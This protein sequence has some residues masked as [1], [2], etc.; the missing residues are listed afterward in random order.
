MDFKKLIIFCIFYIFFVNKIQSFEYR[1]Y[2]YS[3]D[4][5]KDKL[6]HIY[7]TSMCSEYGLIQYNSG[8]SKVTIVKSINYGTCEID[9]NSTL[10][11]TTYFVNKCTKLN[12]ISSVFIRV[13]PDQNPYK[14]TDFCNSISFINNNCDN[15]IVKSFKNNTCFNSNDYDFNNNNNNNNSS[16]NNNNNNNS[17]E[18]NNFKRISCR[19]SYIDIDVCN[20]GCSDIQC[21]FNATI[22]SN[23]AS[24]PE[25][26]FQNLHNN[27]Q[28][29]NISSILLFLFS[30]LLILLIF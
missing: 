30:I 8:D 26:Q 23:S 14:L 15:V 16:N 2:H 28:K 10:V 21:N 5:C 13:E 12:S 3:S 6:H 18:I 11:S 25:I 19:G 1:E 17:T 20:G 27:S 29:L 9:T 4:N 22:D 7:S 24:C